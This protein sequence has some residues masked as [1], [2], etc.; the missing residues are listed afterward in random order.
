MEF[1]RKYKKRWRGLQSNPPSVKKH[2]NTKIQLHL[3]FKS[4]NQFSTSLQINTDFFLPFNIH[5]Q[6]HIG[7]SS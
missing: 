5:H 3:T 4:L 2:E 6:S 7:D 1:L